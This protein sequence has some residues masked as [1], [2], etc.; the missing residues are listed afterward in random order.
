MPKKVTMSPEEHAA[1]RARLEAMSD[2]DFTILVTPG[3]TSPDSA[4]PSGT[5]RSDDPASQP[6]TTHLDTSALQPGASASTAPAPQAAHTPATRR[7]RRVPFGTP[8]I[9]S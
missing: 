5:A 9:P 7:R 6:D 2:D 3:P 4:A 1:L 8:S